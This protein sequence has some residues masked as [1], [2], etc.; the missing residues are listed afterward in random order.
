MK[1]EKN[2]GQMW[3]FTLSE[4]DRKKKQEWKV[5]GYRTRV[6]VGVFLAILFLF[7]VFFQ[8]D[9]YTVFIL[10]NIYRS[11]KGKIRENKINKEFPIS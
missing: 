6:S 9:K 4:R 10:K 8:G 11:W 3:Q 1:D 7:C 5:C 2:C